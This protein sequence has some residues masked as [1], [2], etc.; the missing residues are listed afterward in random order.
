[1]AAAGL[2]GPVA[3]IGVGLIGGSLGLA[4]REAGVADIRGMDPADGAVEDAL[5]RGAITRA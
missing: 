4:L 1:M 2:G 3:L 5:A